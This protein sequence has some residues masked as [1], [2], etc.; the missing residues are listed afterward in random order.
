[1]LLYGPPGVGKFEYCLTLVNLWLSKGERVIF[2]TTERSPD[3]I[4]ERASEYGIDLESREGDR[5]LFIDC[6]SWSIGK[7]YEKG[8]TIENPANINEISIVIE[9]AT[10]QMEKPLRIVFDSLSPLFL[11]N[12]P[13]A[14]SKFFQVLNSRVKSEY[15][16]ILYTLQQGVHDPQIVNTLIYLVDG[17]L[18]MRFAEE[19]KLERMFRV[20]HM[21]GRTV[22]T[23]W[24]K[25]E[26]GD[27]GFEFLE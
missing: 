4:K 11:H 3:E 15:G 14:M 1:M 13:E 9:K 2:I 10:G 6:Y 7:S 27:R 12:P 21:K 16:F 25:F 5:F 23:S 20:H 19:E 24:K 26:I 22:D 8:F 17:Y 18:E